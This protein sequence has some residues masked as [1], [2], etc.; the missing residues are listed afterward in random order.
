[1]SETYYKKLYEPDL[2]PDMLSD[3][4]RH[5]AIQR[6]WRQQNGAWALVENPYV[7]DWSAAQKRCTVLEGLLPAL[8][9][10]GAVFAA[11]DGARLVGFAALDGRARGSRGQYRWLDMLHV[12]QGWRGRGIGGQLLLLAQQAARAMGAE[13]LYISAHSAEESQ[14]FYRAK[15]CICARE[16]LADIAA[17]EPFDVQMELKATPHK[18]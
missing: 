8:R 13:S 18:A 3:F 6:C 7:E 4:D 11:Y 15:G 17:A 12:S 16:V 2:S 1:M 10:G 14:A 9:S 5:Q